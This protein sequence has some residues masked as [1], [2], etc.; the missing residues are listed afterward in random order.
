MTFMMIID[1]TTGRVVRDRHDM[2][3]PFSAS[4]A[5]STDGVAFFV[6]SGSDYVNAV[7]LNSNVVAWETPTYSP[8]T[9]PPV[10]FSNHVYAGPQGN[11]FMSIQLTPSRKILWTQDLGG[12]VTAGFYAGAK[13][14]FVPCEDMRIYAF[15]SFSGDDLWEQPFMTGGPCRTPIQVGDD[16][17]FQYAQGDRLYAINVFTGEKR[18]DMPTGRMVLALM[19]GKAYVLDNENVL[20]IVD[21]MSGEVEGTLSMSSF[22]LFLPNTTAPAI[23]AAGRDGQLHCIRLLDAPRLTSQMLEAAPRPR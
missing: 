19:D 6:G 16:T 17:L 12:S 10:Y 18:W 3:L 20:H 7:D 2:P 23:F 5:G 1:R 15:D 14:C 4:T 13:G 22:D 8:L 21:E 9:V 11:I